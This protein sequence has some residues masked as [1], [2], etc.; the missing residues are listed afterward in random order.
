MY[1]HQENEGEA[2]EVHILVILIVRTEAF[3]PGLSLLFELKFKRL[4]LTLVLDER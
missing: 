3:V 4:I 1:Q 2:F